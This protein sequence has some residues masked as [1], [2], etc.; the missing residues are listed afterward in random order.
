MS[1]ANDALKHAVEEVRSRGAP[2]ARLITTTP[3]VG[4]LA[5]MPGAY[6]PPTRAHLALAEAARDRGFGAVL[7]SLGTVTLDKPETGLPLHER[8]RL[9]SQIVEGR[10]RLGVVLQNRGLYAEQAEALWALPGVAELTFVVGM[11]KIEQIFDPSYYRDFAG[12]LE[13]LFARARLLVAARGDLDRRA[14]DERL[15]AEPARR[16]ADRIDWLALD[17][18][19]RPLSASAVRERL[20]RGETPS[21]WLPEPVERHLRRRGPIF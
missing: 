1:M 21:G 6:N 17:P 19:W 2:T 16:F 5:V 15:A 12:T 3:A 4:S 14:F 7:F 8:L 10:E 18:R 9:L 11:D 13:R 20:A